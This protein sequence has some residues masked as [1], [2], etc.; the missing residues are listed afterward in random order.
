M[1]AA[2]TI[3]TR[4]SVR[5]YDG[6]P[7][8]AEKLDRV[9]AFAAALGNP[10]GIPV[11]FVFLDAQAQGLSSPVL[12]GETLYVAGKVAKVPYGDVAFGSAMEL[13]D[14]DVAL[15]T[16]VGEDATDGGGVGMLQRITVVPEST[17]SVGHAVALDKG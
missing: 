10:F 12:T 17:E 3:L 5:T 1:I 2:E 9:K 8:E 14:E 7:V 16:Q 4:K 6:R 13:D 11:T 15:A